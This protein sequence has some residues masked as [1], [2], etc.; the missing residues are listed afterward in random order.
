MSLT[1]RG[2]SFE[3]QE[4]I[5]FNAAFQ[6]TWRF[7]PE[8]Y[9]EHIGHLTEEERKDVAGSYAKRLTCGDHAVELAAMK[10]YDR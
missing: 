3:A 4:E 7:R 10:V 9:E 1:L 5:D 2:I 8:L 6:R